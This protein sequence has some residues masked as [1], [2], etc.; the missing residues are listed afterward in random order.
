MKKILVSN[1]K[2]NLILLL[3][4]LL[5]LNLTVCLG[6]I[7]PTNLYQI[8]PDDKLVPYQI[9]PADITVQKASVTRPNEAP[10]FE[11]KMTYT[12]KERL[13][14]V[15][16]DKPN[17][18][19]VEQ[20][21][22]LLMVG[23]GKEISLGQS[24]DLDED[25]GE[26][27]IGEIADAEIKAY[28]DPTRLGKIN[29]HFYKEMKWIP[30]EFRLEIFNHQRV[31]NIMKYEYDAEYFLNFA[32]Q[33]EAMVDYDV[34]V[35][36]YLERFNQ[37]LMT[38]LMPLYVNLI[39]KMH[40][41][42]PLVNDKNLAGMRSHPI[43]DMKQDINKM[44]EPY[45][46]EIEKNNLLLAT[47]HK[48]YSEEIQEIIQGGQIKEMLLQGLLD[49]ER[50]L[51]L[52]G[53]INALSKRNDGQKITLANPWE[54]KREPLSPIYVQLIM[55]DM[56]IDIAGDAMIAKANGSEEAVVHRT[57]EEKAESTNPVDKFD[58]IIY[59]LI[60]RIHEG[61][62][63]HI[64]KLGVPPELELKQIT[65]QFVE[66]ANFNKFLVKLI[67]E[68]SGQSLANFIGRYTQ[69]T[70]DRTFTDDIFFGLE[71]G[72]VEIV[73]PTLEN[74]L[75]LLG[76]NMA[77]A[78]KGS[79]ILVI[80]E[81]GQELDHEERPDDLGTNLSSKSGLNLDE[82]TP[83]QLDTMSSLERESEKDRQELNSLDEKNKNV[84][85]DSQSQI[86][87]DDKTPVNLL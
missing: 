77:K 16:K 64:E 84:V 53:A 21:D 36:R 58:I 63:K 37:L 83:E 49:R 40:Q 79:Y 11:Y 48:Y 15:I 42:K 81:G 59:H 80:G 51:C 1:T 71:K 86:D 29:M 38:K 8:T 55:K 23:K 30:L 33:Q 85:I 60:V 26:D 68:N 74:Y 66:A 82:Q 45:I 41:E 56:L 5:N 32:N 14:L 28:G 44:L 18:E 54:L 3:F 46:E 27:Q 35:K 52:D 4:S 10:K 19:E 47:L 75:D 61:F 78:N 22:L 87:L 65:E 73:I 2:R 72:K 67:M 76:E 69:I 43:E 7:S 9:S 25:L 34:M 17:K 31:M 62:K 20:G 57:Y 13:D 39:D 6:I 50:N 12:P 24:H 70:I